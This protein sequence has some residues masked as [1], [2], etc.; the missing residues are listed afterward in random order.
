MPERVAAIDVGTNA[1]R[2]FA[3]ETDGR[4]GFHVLRESRLGGAPRSW[5]LL[6]RADRS[7]GRSRGSSGARAG[8]TADG[9]ALD[10]RAIGPWRPAPSGKA[11]TGGASSGRS[12]EAS[13]LRLEV[14]AGSEE[15]RLVHA[16]VKRRMALGK[17]TW[18]A[19]RAGRR[20]R[21]DRPGGR[22]AR[23]LERDPCHGGRAAHGDVRAGELRAEGVFPADPG[24]R[25]DH[26]TAGKDRRAR[27]E[28]IP[29]HG[30]QH[31][32]HR[33]DLSGGSGSRGGPA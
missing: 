8:G 3:A 7:G 12:A 13:G 9:G 19:R 6:F 11:R 14:I 24:V 25:G 29:R 30:R 1:I 10:R 20:K 18:V 5:G 17:D 23:E 27:C 28:G 2:F 15:I 16:A 22:F 4:D 31:R 32:V 33:A 26:S 21:G